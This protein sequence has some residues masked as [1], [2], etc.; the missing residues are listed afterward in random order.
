MATN[1]RC[2]RLYSAA[3]FFSFHYYLLFIWFSAHQRVQLRML[4][5]VIH[6]WHDTVAAF[7]KSLAESHVGDV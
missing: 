1:F 4:G 5:E 7:Q 2:G 3:R 6:E